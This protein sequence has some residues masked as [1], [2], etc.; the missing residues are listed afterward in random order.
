MQ[1]VGAAAGDERGEPGGDR[2]EEGGDRP[3]P[4]PD[5]VRDREQEPEEDSQA[6]AAK[7]VVDG[8]RSAGSGMVVGARAESTMLARWRVTRD[9]VL[10]AAE[11]IRGRVHRTPTFSSRTLGARRTAQGGAVPEDRLVQGARRPQQALVADAGGEGA[12]RDRD[13]GRQPRPGARVG[14]GA[15]GDRLPRRHVRERERGEGRRDARR[16]APTVDLE[17]ADAVEAFAAA[18]RAHPARRGGRS[19]TRSTTRS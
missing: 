15:G 3:E 10:R 16:T 2:G 14:R 7:I 18:G 19:S 11:R 6:R 12:R 13:L 8:D 17:A 5:E 9:D 1:P 4:E